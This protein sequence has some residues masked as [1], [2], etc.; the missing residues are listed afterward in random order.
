MGIA[1][2]EGFQGEI[3]GSG[4]AQLCHIPKRLLR[5]SGHLLFVAARMGRE[6]R[7]RMKKLFS[8]G[9]DEALKLPGN[10]RKDFSVLWQPGTISFTS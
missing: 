1:C 6:E 10:C 9:L 4:S 5:N 2:S 3:L 8:S 7:K